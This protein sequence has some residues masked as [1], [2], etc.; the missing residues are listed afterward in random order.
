VWG[1]GCEVWGVGFEVWGVRE[2]LQ[3]PNT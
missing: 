3:V 2:D 1:V